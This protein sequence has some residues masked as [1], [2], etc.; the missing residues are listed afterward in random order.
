VADL[1]HILAGVRDSASRQVA[2]D[3]L[4][5]AGR[6]AE[7]GLMRDGHRLCIAGVRVF[8]VWVYY[9]GRRR[10]RGL[11][12]GGPANVQF[13]VTGGD[14]RTPGVLSSYCFSRPCRSAC[15]WGLARRIS[16]AQRHDEV[17]HLSEPEAKLFLRSVPL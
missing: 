7:A 5:D 9:S 1:K 14:V 8:R 17:V 15:L 10:G 2:A 16:A 13:D 4:I 6:E 12:R 3:A 11:N